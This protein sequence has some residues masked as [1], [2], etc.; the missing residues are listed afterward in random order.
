MA[1]LQRTRHSG[2]NTNNING[3]TGKNSDK[4]CN[5]ISIS[6]FTIY[7]ICLHVHHLG[8]D[9]L[10]LCFN[11]ILK[12]FQS[13]MYNTHKHACG[14]FDCVNYLNFKFKTISL[15]NGTDLKDTIGFFEVLPC[16]TFFP[17]FSI[18]QAQA[19]GLRVNY[20]Q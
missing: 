17:C 10:L 19:R 7:K 4:D 15:V 14:H 2:G 5:I 12:I 8:W 1:C 18:C 3:L 13:Y 20:L 6:V 9:V 16:E 11:E